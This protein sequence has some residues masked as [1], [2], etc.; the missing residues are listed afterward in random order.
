M[1]SKSLL[2]GLLVLAAPAIASAQSSPAPPAAPA[3]AASP[4]PDPHRYSDRAMTFVAPPGFYLAGMRK[5]PLAALGE[6]LEPVAVWVI[7]PGKEDTRVIQIQM[8]AYTGPP[9]QWEAQF[10]SQTHSADNSALIRNKTPMS[11]LNGMPASF[12]TVSTGS[13]F[14]SR[15]EFAVVFADNQRG[16]VISETGRLGEIS[17][18]Q[19]RADLRDAKAVAYPMGEP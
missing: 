9:N 15:K 8:E 14:S 17:S 18:H 2:V 10:E 19:A 7:N 16:I 11:L 13:G 12:V 3:P 1:R 4:T 6:N 5:V